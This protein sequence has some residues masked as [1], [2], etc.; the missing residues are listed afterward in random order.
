MLW[1]FKP[2]D[3]TAT[4][5]TRLAQVDGSYLDSSIESFGTQGYV[6]TAATTNTAGYTLW[7]F[8]R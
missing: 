4:H 2:T 3:S 1:G 7:G 6:I 5:D 8:A